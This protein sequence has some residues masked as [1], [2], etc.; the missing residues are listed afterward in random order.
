MGKENG[1]PMVKRPKVPSGIQGRVLKTVF[2]MR[3]KGA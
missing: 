3:V 2:R 1:Q